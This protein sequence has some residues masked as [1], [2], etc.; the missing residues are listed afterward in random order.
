MKPG[1][2][3]RVRDLWNPKEPPGLGV[4]L[5]VETI[6]HGGSNR[7]KLVLQDGNFAWRFE[8]ELEVVG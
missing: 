1:D 2:L 5:S 4:V 3:V 7:C 8:H 6:F